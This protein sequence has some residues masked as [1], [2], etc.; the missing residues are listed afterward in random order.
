MT[1]VPERLARA[2]EDRYR[3]ER[4]LG[5]GG[6]ATVYLAH[7]LKH[8][9]PVALKVLRPE[10]AAVV[11]AERFL[12][13]I[14]VTANLQ[15]PHILPLFDSGQADGFLF[16]VMPYVEGESLQERLARE[17][18]LPVEEAVAMAVKVGTALE[19]AHDQG[20]VH[21]DVKPANVLLSRGE[22][23]V[24]D[25]GIALALS[26]AG[27]GRITETGL[28]LGTPHY[29]SPE[30]AAGERSLDKRSD[31]YALGCVLYEMLTGQ[32]PYSGPTAQAILGRILTADPVPP[33]EH[34]KAIPPHVEHAIL[35]ALEKLPADRFDSAAEFVRALHDRAFRHAEGAG[36]GAPLGSGTPRGV[37]WAVL[38]AVAAVSALAGAG[39]ARVLRSEEGPPAFRQRVVLASDPSA[40]ANWWVM[41]ATALE[42]GGEGI[43]FADTA[44]AGGGWNLWWKAGHEAD[45]VLIPN[46]ERA[47]SPTFSPDG[48]WLAY[49]TG[50]ELRKRPLVGGASIL[51][52]DSAGGGN[53][54]AVAWLEDGTILFE[55]LAFGL[56]RISEDGGPTELLTT[57]ADFGS[58][59]RVSGLVGGGG[60]LMIGCDGSTCPPGTAH[61]FLLDFARDTIAPLIPEVVAAWH[62]EKGRVV[63][64][65]ARG[66]VFTAALDR[67]A[68]ALGP[69]TPLFDGVFGSSGG[70]EM[71]LDRDGTILYRRGGTIWTGVEGEFPNTELVWV[72]RSGEVTPV[73]PGW[74]FHRGGANYGWR[75]SPGGRRVAYRRL[76]EGNR[77]IWIKELPDGPERRLTFEED[78]QRTP[79]W[80]ADG[81]EVG[82]VSG[83]G[84]ASRLEAR[85]ADFTGSARLLLQG[86]FP[87]GLWSPDGTWLVLRTSGASAEGAEGERDIVGFRPG[88][89]TL[90]IPLVAT[91]YAEESPGFSP[92]GRW[93]AYAS[94][95]TGR[96]EVFVVPFPDVGSGKVQVSRDGGI[97]PRW[98]HSGRELFFGSSAGLMVA[99]VETEP[100]FRV[101]AQDTLFPP[102]DGVLAAGTSDWYEVAPDDQ[103]FL[104]GQTPQF[105]GEDT[106]PAVYI[107]V[108]NF[109]TELRER[110]GR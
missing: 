106:G 6:M 41:V 105:E 36:A 8:E 15:H 80:S 47:S 77:D 9:R 76:L 64:V 23:L 89:D 75:L 55:D 88:T 52:S 60:A 17:H 95:E 81:R 65:D 20:V 58:V 109:F 46:T 97:T 39:G 70:R 14:R 110:M 51:L 18:Q 50:N 32:P 1:D 27:G 73:D 19:Y 84:D 49:R 90:P 11:G 43:V 92:D 101:L 3:I 53:I 28:S 57:R 62:V 30:Q 96:Y 71:Q 67:D 37:R 29:M 33:T 26:E 22:P 25:F 35:R 107:L 56:R 94:N 7:D 44:G 102:R 42:P 4:P 59:L 85:S 103:R 16:Y 98:A 100:R 2:L 69:A 54:P 104:M 99:S 93:L 45:A 31:V 72:S 74:M 87:Q 82:Y 86:N 61:L 5:E 63:Y 13:E 83:V 21:R 24:S 38:A 34:R 12:A 10:L 78:G 48:R 108:Q 91:G 40:F 68:L 79:M 66:A